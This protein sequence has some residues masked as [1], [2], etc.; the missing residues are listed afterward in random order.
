LSA[1]K[2]KFEEAEKDLPEQNESHI[3]VTQN[4]ISRKEFK[5]E[6]EQ[7]DISLKQLEKE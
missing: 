1:L 5:I 7:S 2:V 4:T 6:P 3:E